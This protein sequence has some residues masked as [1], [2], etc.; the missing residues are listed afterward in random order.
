MFSVYLL[1]EWI[2]QSDV[3]KAAQWRVE[4][5]IKNV[6]YL[7]DLGAVGS[8]FD[9]K[10]FS[11]NKEN[12]NA[13]HKWKIQNTPQKILAQKSLAREEFGVV[14]VHIELRSIFIII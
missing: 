11:A 7:I 4:N 9:K 13:K 10:V 14:K 2:L 1:A 8:Q 6:F 12:L 5:Y 3:T